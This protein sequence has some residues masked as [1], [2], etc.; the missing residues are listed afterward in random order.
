MFLLIDEI[1]KEKI[2][3]LDEN[4]AKAM[5]KIIYG[6]VETAKTGNGGESMIIECVD[7]IHGFYE[8]LPG[9]KE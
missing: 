5:L 7:K 3:K 9:V 8:S 2:E 1:V 6:F 4:E